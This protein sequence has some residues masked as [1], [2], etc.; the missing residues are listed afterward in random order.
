M[1]IDVL[2]Y[3]AALSIH[4]SAGSLLSKTLTQ[5]CDAVVNLPVL[6]DHGIPMR[7]TPMWPTFEVLVQPVNDDDALLSYAG[8]LQPLADGVHQRHARRAALA[9][10]TLSP[11]AAPLGATPRRACCD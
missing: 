1:G 11:R 5:L 2:G 10:V 4:G 7:A 6:K 9:R 8:L 3:E